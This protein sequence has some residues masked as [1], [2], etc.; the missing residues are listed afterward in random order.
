MWGQVTLAA[1][2]WLVSSLVYEPESFLPPDSPRDNGIMDMKV[3]AEVCSL[4]RSQTPPQDRG[5]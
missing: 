2:S 1:T 5:P 3:P 4:P